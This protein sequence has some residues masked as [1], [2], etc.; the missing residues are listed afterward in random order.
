MS[1]CLKAQRDE[2]QDSGALGSR[3]KCV[4]GQQ[5]KKNLINS[6]YKIGREICDPYN[7][8]SEIPTLHSM[9]QVEFLKT[10]ILDVISF[11]LSH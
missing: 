1:P 2:T 7:T 3:M 4:I 8:S 10:K 11:L 5:E 9:I 6:K